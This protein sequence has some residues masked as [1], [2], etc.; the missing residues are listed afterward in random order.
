MLTNINKEYIVSSQTRFL[1]N[2]KLSYLQAIVVELDTES[3]EDLIEDDYY[4][5]YDI[6]IISLSN[7]DYEYHNS[8]VELLRF[9]KLES[10]KILHSSLFVSTHSLFEDTFS[11]I[12]RCVEE[13]D[14]SKIKMKQLKSVGSDISNILN[15]FKLVHGIEFHEHHSMLLTLHDFI[16]IRNT[17]VHQNGHIFK[18]DD[19]RRNKLMKFIAKR[20]NI[21]LK[22]DSIL[23]T[24]KFVLSYIKFLNQL[25]ERL[26]DDIKINSPS[27]RANPS[28]VS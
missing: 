3:D 21:E 8:E 1:Y 9:A 18:L 6:E 13:L 24:K 14:P 11:D 17:I 28:R 25:G 26:F 20:A 10:N 27:Y 22:E 2:E 19:S 16:L 12:R 7:E 23:I 4:A 15:Y 5:R